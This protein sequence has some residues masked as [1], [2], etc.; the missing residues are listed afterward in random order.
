MSGPGVILSYPI[1]Q[2]KFSVTVL[3]AALGKKYIIDIKR[4]FNTVHMY[5]TSV[6]EKYVFI[7]FY[8]RVT[9]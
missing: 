4:Y 3:T 6:T 8:Y 2:N 5:S 7:N 9:L 1:L